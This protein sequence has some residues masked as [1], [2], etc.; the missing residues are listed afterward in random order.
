[1]ESINQ[2]APIENQPPLFAPDGGPSEELKKALK[3]IEDEKNREY[4]KK[5]DEEIEEMAEE[6]R[7]N[8][9]P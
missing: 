8:H 1:M 4:Q 2:P 3:Q 6:R 9:A 7:Q 5:L